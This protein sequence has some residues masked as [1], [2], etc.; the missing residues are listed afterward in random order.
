M[1][2]ATSGIGKATA[3]A[4]AAFGATLVI[5]G[6]SRSKV[7]RTLAEIKAASGNEDIHVLLADFASLEQVATLARNFQDQFGVLHV[8]INN[9]GL[10]T[11][12]HQISSDGFELTFA[13]NH[14]APFLLTHR[15]L[16]TLS[17][18]APARIATNSSTAMGGGQIRFDDL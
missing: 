10:L 5:H 12:H 16:G 1:T 3:H 6:R 7:E 11:D 18:S 4:L 14:L 2:G 15:L 13:V 9:A 8:L 17:D